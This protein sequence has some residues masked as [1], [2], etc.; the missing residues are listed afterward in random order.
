[1]HTQQAQAYVITSDHR[2]FD[3]FYVAPSTHHI[4]MVM[5]T[6][7]ILSTAILNSVDELNSMQDGA[8]EGLAKSD[9]IAA[10][11]SNP[12]EII[13]G[14]SFHLPDATAALQVVKEHEHIFGED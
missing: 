6:A 12:I 9:V 8:H 1:M 14:P 10:Q 13:M 7:G 5:G 2:D 11:C 3:H 4:T